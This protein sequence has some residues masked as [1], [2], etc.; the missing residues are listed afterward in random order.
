MP[1]TAST[2]PKFPARN[3]PAS[4]LRS[5]AMLVRRGSECK[6]YREPI[7][8]LSAVHDLN[9]KVPDI[10]SSL[11]G[12]KATGGRTVLFSPRSSKP[13]SGF[14]GKCCSGVRLRPAGAM[15]QPRESLEKLPFISL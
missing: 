6:T 13:P 14:G 11:V 2:V 8:F 3:P 5:S 12:R 1:E 15:I 4:L 9:G 10:V 7:S